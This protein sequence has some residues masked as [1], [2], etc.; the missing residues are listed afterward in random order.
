[1]KILS[2]DDSVTIRRII[3]SSVDVL[4]FGFLEAGNGVEALTVLDREH[5]DIALVLL[6]WNMPFMDGYTLLCKM[7]EDDRYRQIPV[8]MVTTEGEKSKIA[9]AIAAGATNYLVKPFSQ[10]DL[11]TKIMES[12]GL[13]V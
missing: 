1:M 6:D 8:T 5:A 9:Q 11:T 10:E 4:G 13:G 7:K 12:L 3:Q 2:V